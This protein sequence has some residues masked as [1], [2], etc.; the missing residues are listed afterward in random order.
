[1]NNGDIPITEAFSSA[2]IGSE[3][4]RGLTKRELFTLVAMHGLCANSVP[5]A[6][7]IPE[8]LIKEAIYLAD[9]S[10]KALENQE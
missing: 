9:G 2:L 8:N 3:I 4:I 7:H 10:L 5:G 1:M 6:H